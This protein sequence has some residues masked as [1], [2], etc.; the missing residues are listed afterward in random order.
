MSF[1]FI[2]LT[3]AD[4]APY[5][6]TAVVRNNATG[7]YNTVHFGNRNYEDYTMHKDETR[8]SS[9]IARHKPRE[10]WS[11]SGANTAGYWSK[12]L[13]WNK[14]TIRASLSDIK[15]TLK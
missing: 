1:Q 2:S 7:R 13:L 9:Y 3:K 11:A 5:K 4:K 12:N 14:K 6:Y 8:K 15:S 10:N